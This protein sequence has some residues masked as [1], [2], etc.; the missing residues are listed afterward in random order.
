MTNYIK[1]KLLNFCGR[2]YVEREKKSSDEIDTL[3]T[4]KANKLYFKFL[5]KILWSQLQ[6]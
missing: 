2:C 5:D 1:K 4:E 6:L 3:S